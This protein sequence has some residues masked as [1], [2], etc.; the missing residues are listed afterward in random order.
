MKKLLFLSVAFAFS[1][2]V[3]LHCQNPSSADKNVS[4]VSGVL[5]NDNGSRAVGAKVACIPRNH[6]PYSGSHSGGDS[7]VTDDTGAYKFATMAADTYD[8]L[9][10]IDTSMAFRDPVIVTNDQN[11]HVPHD[12]LRPAGSIRG[13]VRFDNGGDMGTVFILFFGT[14]TFIWPDDSLGNF[15]C[16]PL[17][18]GQYRVRILTTTPNY[19][20]AN[21]TFNVRAGKNDTLTDTIVLKYTGIPIPQGVRINYDTLMQI[22][23]LN[24]KKP[25][26]GTIVQSYTV[27]RKRSDSVS[28]VSIR[29]G[30]TDTTYSDSTAEQYQ[31][32]QYRVAVVDTNYTE[33]V[34]SAGVNV[35]IASCF[36]VDTVFDGSVSGPGQFLGVMNDIAIDSN[37]NLYLVDW[38]YGKV[39]IFDANCHFLREFSTGMQQSPNRLDLDDSCNIY[40][41]E[42]VPQNSGLGMRQIMVCDP[43]GTHI[44]SIWFNEFISDFAIHHDEI[45]IVLGDS[46]GADSVLVTKLDGTRMRSFRSIGGKLGLIGISDSGDVFVSDDACR[47]QI[48]DTS[49]NF[50]SAVVPAGS[51]G[52]YP[53]FD[54]TGNCMMEFGSYYPLYY[55]GA[56][57][58]QCG[59]FARYRL[60]TNTTVLGL[61]TTKKGNDFV[62]VLHYQGILKLSHTF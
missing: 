7:T 28:F 62:Y 35:F 5:F 56:F 15:A 11:T 36:H 37:N 21:D 38:F 24:W 43:T 53:V 1:I 46:T 54:K 30:V 59:L 6:D 47:I 32:Y 12:T 29:A 26:N 8:I 41:G 33:G 60:D 51:C 44:D 13:V 42:Q 16:G 58:R 49:G 55:L 45:Y 19:Q 17:A 27:Y 34:K 61:C 3:L 39:F 10:R 23:N 40:I 50:K 14:K 18:A 31:T 25:T 2:V 4:K 22:V 20:Y 9:S 48:F 52:S 57:N